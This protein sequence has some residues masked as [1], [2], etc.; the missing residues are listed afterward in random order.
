MIL[1]SCH[2]SNQHLPVSTHKNILSLGTKTTEM[3]I[4]IFSP[5]IYIHERE[6]TSEVADSIVIKDKVLSNIQKRKLLLHYNLFSI[7][8]FFGTFNSNILRCLTI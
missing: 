5:G 6:I 8:Q 7:I 4:S 3:F 1:S 2:I